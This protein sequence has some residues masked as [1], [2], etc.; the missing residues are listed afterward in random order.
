MGYI[1]TI[2]FRNKGNWQTC[3]KIGNVGSQQDLMPTRL[4]MLDVSRDVFWMNETR[5]E[6]CKHVE[7]FK[8]ISIFLELQN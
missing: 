3:N 6:M 8:I 4:E 5:L 1:L 2:N 7:V